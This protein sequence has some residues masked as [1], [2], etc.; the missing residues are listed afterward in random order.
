MAVEASTSDVRNVLH[1]VSPLIPK[2]LPGLSQEVKSTLDKI[3]AKCTTITN[4][5]PTTNAKLVSLLKV[6]QYDLEKVTDNL[7]CPKISSFPMQVT[8]YLAE[9]YNLQ[10]ITYQK[11]PGVLDSKNNRLPQDYYLAI[12]LQGTAETAELSAASVEEFNGL[13]TC[14]LP[15]PSPPIQLHHYAQLHPIQLH[16]IHNSAKTQLPTTTQINT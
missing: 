14:I 15:A 11:T 9:N 16:P 3:G 5:T 7:F 2:P 4:S 1:Q 10:T 12:L 6:H 13:L 8:K